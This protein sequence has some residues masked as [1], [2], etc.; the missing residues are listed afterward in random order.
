MTDNIGDTDVDGARPDD[1]DG[2]LNVQTE[3][4]CANCGDECL[5]LSSRDW[6]D[7]C[8]EDAE[9]VGAQKCPYCGAP[10]DDC[11]SDACEERL[12]WWRR[13]YEIIDPP[14]AGV[15]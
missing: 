14:C 10:L 15:D 4:P 13:E 6:C 5:T 8:E 3:R 7:G 2:D 11:L 1:D 12:E 9:S